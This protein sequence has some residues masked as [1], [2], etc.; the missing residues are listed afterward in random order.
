MTIIIDKG[1]IDR[2]TAAIERLKVKTYISGNTITLSNRGKV[3]K[4]PMT[5]T[6]NIRQGYTR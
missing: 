3:V 5:R 1:N 4:L 2:L 6:T